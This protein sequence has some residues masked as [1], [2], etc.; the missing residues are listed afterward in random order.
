MS[1]YCGA[2]VEGLDSLGYR[3]VLSVDRMKRNMSQHEAKR[4][5]KHILYGRCIPIQTHQINWMSTEVIAVNI[6]ATQ[7]DENVRI[8]PP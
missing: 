6:Y 5:Q 3:R 7:G 2:K 4:L 1:I 8:W